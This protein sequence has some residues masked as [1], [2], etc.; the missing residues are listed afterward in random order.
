MRASS[1]GP[2]VGAGAGLARREGMKE[3]RRKENKENIVAAALKRLT[4]IFSI[5]LKRKPTHLEDVR[6]TAT[7]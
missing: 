1:T 2:G 7:L 3:S 4:I 5:A 6:T